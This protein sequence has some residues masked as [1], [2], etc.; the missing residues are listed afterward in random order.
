MP[1]GLTNAPATFQAYINKALMGILD[2]FC[3][4]FIDDICIYSDT[5]EEH[6]DHVRQVLDRLRKADLHVKLSKCEFSV[7]N[8]AF[9]GYRVGTAG[10]SMDP[11]KVQTIFDWPVPESFRD[12]QVFLGFANFYKRFVLRYSKIVRPMTDLF[13]RMEKGRKIEPFEWPEETQQAFE[14]LKTC[15]TTAPT[16][17]N[18]EPHRKTRVETDASEAAVSG[19]LSQLVEHEGSTRGVWHPVAYWSR[20]LTA[21]ERNYGTFDAELLAI[22][23][24]FREWRSYL[25]GAQYT[26]EV[27]SDHENLQYFITTK[28]LNRQ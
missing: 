26:V 25:E 10:V 16:L 1:F 22:V 6:A 2:V 13:K 23:E 15:F 19:I 20:K 27:I 9:L 21:A 3:V 18:Y 4:A 24:A 8:I 7:E 11:R 28:V 14:V 12:I 17:Q 5:V